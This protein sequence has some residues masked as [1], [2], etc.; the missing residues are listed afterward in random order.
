MNELIKIHIENT[1]CTKCFHFPVCSRHMGGMDLCKCEDFIPAA[2][3]APVVYGMWTMCVDEADYEYGVCSVCGYIE[4]DAFPRGDIPNFC[5]NC[6][7]DMIG[8]AAND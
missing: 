4:G 7:A 2:N 3:V 5:P 8:V 1:E 6:G